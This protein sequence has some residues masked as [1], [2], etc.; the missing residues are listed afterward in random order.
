VTAA[1]WVT[2][3]AICD[4]DDCAELARWTQTRDDRTTRVSCPTHPHIPPMAALH[5]YL[6]S[7]R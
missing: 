7:T 5:G 6:R 1:E 2:F 4:I 3:P